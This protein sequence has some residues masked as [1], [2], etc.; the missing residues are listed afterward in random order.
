MLG[1]RSG[2]RWQWETSMF[3]WNI[4]GTWPIFDAM[5]QKKLGW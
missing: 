5:Q 3:N 1:H 2:K 4:P